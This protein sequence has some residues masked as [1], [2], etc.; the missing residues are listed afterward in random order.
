MR[1]IFWVLVALMTGVYLTM[2]FWSL[3]IITQAS[4]GLMPFDLRPS[5]YGFEDVMHLLEAMPEDT[6]RFYLQVQHKL[7]SV[8]PALMAV[9][10]V[11][12]FQRLFHGSPKFIFSAVAVLAAGFDYLENAAVAEL[13]NMSMID[14][15]RETVKMASLWTLLKSVAVTLAISALLVG[16]VLAWM[17][18]RKALS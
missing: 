10:F 13:L 8:F 6:K 18:K 7:D 14:L 3:P 11:M 4:G 17:R 1:L 9:V 16:L 2:V 5:G 12:A 15:T